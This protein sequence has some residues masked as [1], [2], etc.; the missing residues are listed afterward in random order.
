MENNVVVA[1]CDE[2]VQRSFACLRFNFRGVGQSTGSFDRGI[3]EQDDIVAAYNFVSSESNIDSGKIGLVGYSFG[4]MVAMNAMGRLTGIRSTVLVSPAIQE[5][6]FQKIVDYDKPELIIIGE[7]DDIVSLEPLQ[8]KLVGST[9]KK[10]CV[11]VRADHFWWGIEEEM[12]GEVVDFFSNIFTD[13]QVS[14]R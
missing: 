13:N 3:R 1:I 5:S 12:A 6:D 2:L 10:V 9:D 7:N 8:E 11:V 4:G 14:D